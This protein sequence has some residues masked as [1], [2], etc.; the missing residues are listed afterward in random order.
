MTT[1]QNKQVLKLV[2]AALIA[3]PL[4][5]YVT[6]S[7]MIVSPATT[8][9][10]ALSYKVPSSYNYSKPLYL[11]AGGGYGNDSSSSS[12]SA[13]AQLDSV[14]ILKDK[15]SDKGDKGD[16]GNKGGDKG[17]K[18]KKP[19]QISNVK[20]TADVDASQVSNATDAAQAYSFTVTSGSFTSKPK[21]LE[22]E[23]SEGGAEALKI[24]FNGKLL[25]TAGDSFTVTGISST[26]AYNTV[27]AS[28]TL[29]EQPQGK[30]GKT[31]IVGSLD[32]PLVLQETAIENLS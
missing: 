9:A 32:S 21:T 15:P 26:D 2:L 19:K 29:T 8:E 17:S 14:Q 11:L 7:A 18:N 31:T 22:G 27:S 12:A 6:A 1:T 3:I 13:L 30:S 28:G 5:T 16:K 24:N 23:S 4:L 20:I 25:V 10:N